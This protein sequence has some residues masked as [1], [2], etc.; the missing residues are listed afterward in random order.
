M[1]VKKTV[2]LME[3][4]NRKIR[5]HQDNFDNSKKVKGKKESKQDWGDRKNQ[6]QVGS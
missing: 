4:H 6:L 5:L 3:E 1:H 2:S